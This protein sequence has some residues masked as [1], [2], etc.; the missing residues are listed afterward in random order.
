MA[1]VADLARSGGETTDT[2]A[3]GHVLTFPVTVADAHIHTL[4]KDGDN[5]VSGS[6]V[7]A[8][9]NKVTHAAAS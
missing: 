4:Q 8:D 5:I 7:S 9:Y 1:I 3:V 6:H 2:D